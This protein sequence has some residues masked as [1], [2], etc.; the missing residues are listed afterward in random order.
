MR[1]HLARKDV[2]PLLRQLERPRPLTALVHWLGSWLAVAGACALVWLSAWWTPVALVVIASRQRALGNILHDSVHGNVMRRP[3]RLFQVVVAAP[4]FESFKRYRRRHMQHH[5]HLG[6]PALDPDFFEVPVGPASTAWSVFGRVSRRPGMWLASVLGDLHRLGA[7]EVIGVLGFW[8]VVLALVG[9]AA[10]PSAV[11]LVAGLWMLSRATTYHALKCFV[12]LGDHYGGLTP[13]SLFGYSRV[14][15]GNALA[16]LIQ[17]YNDRFHL[18]HHLLPRIA[19]ANLPRV[20]RLLEDLEPYRAAVYGGYFLGPRSVAKSFRPM[21]LALALLLAAGCAVSGCAVPGPVASPGGAAGA[22][23]SGAGVLGRACAPCH[24]SGE[25]D[26]PDLSGS[27]PS[28]SG[29]SGSGPSGRGPS[30]EVASRALRAVMAR[31]MPPRSAPELSAE[32]RD[33]LVSFL[34]QRAG[35]REAFC[36]AIARAD[37]RPPIRTAPT[38]FQSVGRVTAREVPEH[39]REMSYLHTDP[40]QPRVVLTPS[41]A[42]LVVL[43][44]AGV[45]GSDPASSG[46]GGAS[47][48]GAS[49]DGAEA[50]E[51][52]RCIRRVLQLG[53]AP[54]RPPA[55]SRARPLEARP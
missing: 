14:Y 43:V 12:E 34:C 29:L 41:G 6:D 5:A 20:H 45:C 52:G 50:A 55:D 18:T 21:L 10:G 1:E 22:P 19:M 40:D 26:R 49:G 36:Q 51:L 27:G 15:P 7:A 39:L 11:L 25:A 9:L 35:H 30:P 24:T 38:F 8:A 31:E 47:G 4:A 37:A 17:P 44:A 33:A 16:L 42:A 48:S 32:S 53:I 23:E 2:L 13:G 54:A 3:S 28:G 46:G